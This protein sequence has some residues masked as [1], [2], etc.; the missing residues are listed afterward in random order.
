MTRFIRYTLAALC[1]AASVGC[2]ALSWRSQ[3]HYDLLVGPCPISPK[4]QMTVDSM[5]GTIGVEVWPENV[6]SQYRSRLSTH[7]RHDESP[8]EAAMRR[9]HQNRYGGEHFGVNG[10]AIHF[11]LWYSAFAFA[12]ASVAAM[13]VGSF[14]IR[15][16]LI[17]TTIV[18]ALLGMVVTL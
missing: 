1:L 11:P 3:T 9:L 2:L 13:R 16:A 8:N 4:R 12:L 5:V 7:W 17:A 15:S 10:T 14:T 18:A 6:T